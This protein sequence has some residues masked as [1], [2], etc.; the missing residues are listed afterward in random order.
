MG[1]EGIS[2]QGYGM[3]YP[4]MNLELFNTNRKSYDMFVLV[5]HI[6]EAKKGFKIKKIGKATKKGTKITY[7]AIES[8][9]DLKQ[10]SIKIRDLLKQYNENYGTKY[11]L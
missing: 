4:P 8:E 10:Y 3:E 6:E 7:T 2:V 5:A 9:E 11:T 1:I